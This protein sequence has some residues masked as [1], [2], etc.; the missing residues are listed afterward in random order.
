MIGF[1]DSGI[2][3]LNILEE[4]HKQ[5]PQLDTYYYADTANCPL[6]DK[7]SEEITACV[8][9]GIEFLI[10]HGCTLVI[11][12]CNTATA[13]TIRYIQNDWLPI[14][15][16]NCNVLGIIRPVVEELLPILLD[17]QILVLATPATVKT[18]FYTQELSDYG[19][20]QVTELAMG[21]LA[22]LIEH[23]QYPEACQLISDILDVNSDRISNAAIVILACTHYP[24][25]QEEFQLILSKHIAQFTLVNQNSLVTQSLIRYLNKHPEYI[26]STSTW[27]YYENLTPNT[28]SS[29]HTVQIS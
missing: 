5:Y 20:T 21:N 27:L 23:N 10:E 22:S 29:P 3:G 14:H 13:S 18:R 7:T 19:Y 25:L 1:Y 4:V 17:S 12:A 11:L 15:H 8:I 24:Y 6:G 16:P 28:Y 9:Q 2:G 26:H